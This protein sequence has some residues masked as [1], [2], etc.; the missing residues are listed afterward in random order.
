MLPYENRPLMEA[1]VSYVK[2]FLEDGQK[3]IFR[4]PFRWHDE[5]GMLQNHFE[6]ASASVLAEEFC[7]EILADFCH[8]AV[9][10]KI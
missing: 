9:I 2:P 3:V 6:S 10:R 5:N 1:I 4:Q 7:Y 8:F